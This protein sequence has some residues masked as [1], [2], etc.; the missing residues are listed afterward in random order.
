MDII[1]ILNQSLGYAF[2]VILT[3]IVMAIGYWMFGK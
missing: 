1:D 3:A 2:V